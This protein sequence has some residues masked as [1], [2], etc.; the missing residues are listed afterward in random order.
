[1]IVKVDTTGCTTEQIYKVVH[2]MEK[3]H[4]ARYDWGYSF[5]RIPEAKVVAY[6]HG[7]VVTSTKDSNWLPYGPF[8]PAAELLGTLGGL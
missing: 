1:M 5:G 4:N 8:T 6:C 2:K 7:N 3:L